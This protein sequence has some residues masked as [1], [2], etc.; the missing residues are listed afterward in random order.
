MARPLGVDAR[1]AVTEHRLNADD[2]TEVDRLRADIARLT[3][4]AAMTEERLWFVLDQLASRESG[5]GGDHAKSDAAESLMRL[6][7]KPSHDQCRD[8]ARGR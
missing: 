8:W 2:L 7:R 1:V 6:L 5:I 4:D 3:Q